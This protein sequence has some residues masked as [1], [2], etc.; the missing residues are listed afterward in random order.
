MSAKALRGLFHLSCLRSKGDVMT[1]R[2]LTT[3]ETTLVGIFAMFIGACIV[4]MS[5]YE[6]ATL[7]QPSVGTSTFR[8]VLSSLLVALLGVP[9]GYAA[10]SLL[11]AIA[12]ALLV[13]LGWR[14]YLRS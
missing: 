14:I 10:Y 9:A 6:L 4:L 12:G 11:W 5:V 1:E 2:K 7:A 13:W 3:R 8:A